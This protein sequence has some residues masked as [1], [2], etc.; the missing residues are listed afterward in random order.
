MTNEVSE[1]QDTLASDPVAELPQINEVKNEE[2]NDEDSSN[3]AESQTKK[4]KKGTTTGK[5]PSAE[6]LQRRKEG[7]RKAA[8]TIANNIK[9]TG[10]GRFEQQ[11]GFTLTSVKQIPL[12]NQKNY[13]TDY[14][15][16]DEQVA[17]IRNWRTEKML[18]QKLKNMKKDELKKD[19]TDN[20]ETKSFDNFNL[21]D[22]E[23]EMNKKKMA[24]PIVEEDDE[25]EEE[26][27]ENENEEISEEKA[28]L[29]FDTIV[30]HPGSSNIRIGR[31]TDAFPKTV[32]TVIAVPNLEKGKHAEKAEPTPVRTVDEEGQVHFND[33]F[34]EVKE[35]V[36]KDFKAR[37]RYYKRRMLPN[38]RE[39]AANYNKRQEPEMIPDH[40]DPMRKEWIDLKDPDYQGRKFFVGDEALNLPICDKFDDWKLR[41]P[42]INGRFNESSD[43]YQSFQEVLGD[44][45]NIVVESLADLDIKKS[46]L[47]NL[48]AILIIPDLYDKMQVETWCDLLFKQ[49]GFGRVG[50]I[51]ESV[52]ATFGAGATS[53]CVVDV[54]AQTTS[55]ACVDEGMVINDSRIVL[56]YGGDH[57]T[58]TFIKLLLQ[59]QLPYKDINLSSRNEDWELAQTLKHN[60]IT[61]QDADIAVQL[62]HFYQRKP[63]ETTKKYEFKVF[64]EVMLAP[65]GLFYPALFQISE[66]A[67]NNKKLFSPSVDQYSGKP[68]NPYSKSQENIMHKFVHAD[69]ADEALLNRI[70]DD[71]SDMK[72]SNP[73]SKPKPARTSTNE[74][75]YLNSST[76]LEKAIIE[77]ITNAGV[78]SDFSRTKKF[79]DNLLVVGGG[80]SKVSGFDLVLSDRI[81]IWRPKFLSSSSLDEVL[82]YVAAERLKVET[83]RTQLIT[84]CKEKKKGPDDALDDIELSEAE[85]ADIDSQTRLSLDLD[86][87]DSISDKGSVLPVNVLPPP[88][89]FD[90][91]MLTWKGGSVYGRLKV[92][93]E[94]WVTQKDW[95][96][97]QSRCLYYK[98][99]FNY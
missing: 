15:K 56:N 63:Y 30:I 72:A 6:V 34:D 83:L 75:P 46:Q 10:I 59:S 92:V 36:T 25:E 66:N 60:F 13:Y 17:F 64:D 3:E 22:I 87:I 79:Y 73:Y 47:L 71:R 41:F 49:V 62:Y 18:A 2:T 11:N 86:Y 70:L 35:V 82:E 31:A 48:K 19:D 57:I 88:R 99:L 14:L 38:S 27:D 5:K 9:K 51:Q 78:V 45:F 74:E 58:E 94:M 77:S 52:L 28:R 90:P 42:I 67:P 93:N 21:N 97:L 16:K 54:G 12:I 23:T 95:D 76:P 20:N 29:G 26:D 8:A 32:P 69:L 98:S 50:I 68:N 53:A 7:R 24:A 4:R 37:M 55:I 40:N 44:L 85:L 39:T 65:L 91:E 96:L 80:F 81:N 61:F 33:E 89:E 1:S 43:D 84:E